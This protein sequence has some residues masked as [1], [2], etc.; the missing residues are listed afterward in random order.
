MLMTIDL[1]ERLLVHTDAIESPRLVGN[2][3]CSETSMNI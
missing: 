2:L 3:V 1:I